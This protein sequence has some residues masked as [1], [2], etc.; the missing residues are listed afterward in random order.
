MGKPEV[1]P[2]A[3][4]LDRD[5]VI[6]KPIIQNGKPYPPADVNEF[7]I[8]ED[9]ILGLDR[10]RAAGYLLIVVTNQPDAAR[11]KQTRA[12]VEA[13]NQKMLET[14]PQ[15]TRIEVCWHAGA[16]WADPC[17]CRKPHPGM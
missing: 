8:Y 11:G 12:A 6:N 16:E 13:I 5:G 1:K 10:L 14:L 7:K 15:I 2:R 3:V 17:E 9:V 4:F